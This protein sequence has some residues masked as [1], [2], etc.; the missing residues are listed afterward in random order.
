MEVEVK[1]L[2][3]SMLDQLAYGD[4]F[5]LSRGT[6]PVYMKVEAWPGLDRENLCA[7]VCLEDGRLTFLGKKTF[8]E[9]AS[10]KLLVEM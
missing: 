6:Y 10:K 4:V 1:T 3:V 5:Q 8:I 2:R 9:A 7:I